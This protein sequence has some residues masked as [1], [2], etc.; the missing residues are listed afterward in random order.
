VNNG[1][2]ISEQH[3]N[4]YLYTGLSQTNACVS[5]NFNWSG[6]PSGGGWISVIIRA[7]QDGTHQDVFQARGDGYWNYSHNSTAF[8]SG[9]LTIDPTQT[10]NV[11][12]CANGSTVTG[13][14]DNVLYATETDATNTGGYAGFG[15]QAP[16]ECGCSGQETGSNFEI[17][18]VN[19]PP[20]V[21]TVTISPN[22]VQINTS[23]TASA[24]F[25]DPDTGDTHTATADFGDGT[26]TNVTCS[27]VTEPSG[28]TP[29]SVSCTLSSGYTA[30]NVYPVTITVSDGTTSTTSAIS[31]ASVYNPTQSSI[32]TAGQRFSNPSTASPSTSGN[33]IFGL[34][35][36][37][38]GGMPTGVRQ[39]SMDFNTAN[40]HFNANYVNSLVISNGMATLT[41]TGTLNG[42]SQTDNF[43]VT[44][45][46]GGGIRIQ[47]TDSSNN[48]VYDTQPGDPITA[49]P[50]TSVTGQVI[51][52]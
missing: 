34:S 5:I 50:T 17:D 31:Y 28:S 12:I 8:D 3:D 4:G 33:V 9:S 30:A 42:G 20:Q 19:T 51:V 14:V 13:F 22:P 29:G 16:A 43:F 52:H 25:T 15:I 45:V 6:V 27:S 24:N 21:G 10:H 48:V 7:S 38:Q 37:Y 26:H 23:V 35:Y 18:S 32:F 2:V 49:T 36:K 40:I 44:G 41:G 1:E 39:F 46:D 11:K 47:I